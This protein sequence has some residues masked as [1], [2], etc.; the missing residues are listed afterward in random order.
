MFGNKK[1]LYVA[2]YANEVSNDDLC[3][4]SWS[5][6]VQ[7]VLAALERDG[8]TVG[9]AMLNWDK[10]YHDAKDYAMNKKNSGRFLDDASP[11]PTFDM[12]QDL[13][14]VS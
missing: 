10:I 9:K 14:T 1:R 4:Y 7:D 6:L 13:E 11:K 3:R 5:L 12:L 2:L 8:R